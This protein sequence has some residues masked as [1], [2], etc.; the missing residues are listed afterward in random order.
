MKKIYFTILAFCL[1]CTIKS[2]VGIYKS[3]NVFSVP[4]ITLAIVDDDTGIQWNAANNFSFYTNNSPRITID[5][6]GNVGIN[7]TNPQ[8][9][10]DVDAANDFI[11]IRNLKAQDAATFSQFLVMDR[12]TSEIGTKTNPSSLG[13]FIRLPF[14]DAIYNAGTTTNLDFTAVNDAAPNGADNVINTIAGSTIND[15]ANTVFLPEG[16]YSINLKLVG[17]FKGLNDN[18]MA[19]IH[20]LVNNNLYVFQPGVIYG[21]AG[22]NADGFNN[23]EPNDSRKTGYLQDIIIVPST[24]AT[25]NFKIEVAQN[26]FHLYKSFIPTG[27]SGYSSRTVLSITKLK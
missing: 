14:V 2:Q 6:T 19:S 9:K 12:T 13:Q 27:S 17:I 18:N 7:Q 1:F 21:Y 3:A 26:N 10:L 25:I 8:Y 11:R 23:G 4:K 15:A 5:A 16:T 22:E 24:G 20:F